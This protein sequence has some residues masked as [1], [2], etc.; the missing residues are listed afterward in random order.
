MVSLPQELQEREAA[1]RRR[2]AE[3][4]DGIEELTLPLE[5]IREDL[6][7][8]VI[9]W[10]AVV[11]VLTDLSAAEAEPEP[12]MSGEGAVVTKG[13]AAPRGVGVMMVPP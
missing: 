8:L 5:K 11:E 2:V 6:S 10:E 4:Q 7:R 1:A 12:E 3:L 9:V 13:A